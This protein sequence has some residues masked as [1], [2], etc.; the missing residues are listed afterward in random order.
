MKTT[1]ECL[2]AAA[3]STDADTLG[4]NS[5]AKYTNRFVFADGKYSFEA[6]CLDDENIWIELCE[7]DEE[8]SSKVL[9]GHCLHIMHNPSLASIFARFLWADFERL[10][11]QESSLSHI[12]KDDFEIALLNGREDDLTDMANYTISQ[13]FA[14]TVEYKKIGN[15]HFFRSLGYDLVWL[16]VDTLEFYEDALQA[17]PE[18]IR[19]QVAI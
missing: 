5:G 8:D 17:L 6:T 9:I 2:I 3:L 1:L 11:Q 15:E 10:L 13:V 7:I 4:N 12:N 14:N 16:N 18:D 19:K